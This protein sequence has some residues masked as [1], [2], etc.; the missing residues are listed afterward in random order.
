MNVEF[1]TLIKDTL[2]FN[3]VAAAYGLEFNRMGF[4]R[5]PFHN[6]K[7]ASF[8]IKNHRMA[9]CFGCGWSGDIID[10][11]G[12][13]FN[14]DFKQ[15]MQKLVSDFNLPITLNR[16]MTLRETRDITAAYNA[17]VTERK[18]RKQAEEE[19]QKRYD[20]LLWV[21]AT[22]DRWKRELKPKSPSD[23]LDERY[24][25]A[26]KELDGAAYRLMLYS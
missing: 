14:L 11:T 22:L 10:F 25:I 6:E 15:S 9:H 21:Y 16:K 4:A 7:T 18:R 8:K 19:K 12:R 23:P 1:S 2:D 3:T 5:C 13:L 17:A 26:C 24:V 20:N